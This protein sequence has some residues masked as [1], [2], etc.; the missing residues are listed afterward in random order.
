MCVQLRSGNKELCTEL[1]FKSIGT[2]NS[3]Q[4][5]EATTLPTVSEL[6]NLVL[7]CRLGYYGGALNGATCYVKY[8]LSTDTASIYYT[9]DLNNITTDHIISID[10]AGPF[11]P[12]DED[13]TKTYYPITISSINATTTPGKGTTRVE[14]GTTEIITIDPTDPTL[15]LA[16]DNGV[17]VTNQLVVS[18]SGT[19]SYTVSSVSGAS[20]G[21]ALNNNNY[22]ESQN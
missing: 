1:N 19:P 13:P 8:H 6:A 3:T 20:Y 18:S 9:Y 22:Y 11:I 15:T 2:S 12:P 21:F 4:T 5:L 14:S 10:A 16:L 7:Y 17:D